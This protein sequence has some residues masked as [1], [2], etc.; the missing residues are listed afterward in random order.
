MTTI[1]KPT[2]YLETSTISYLAAR[3]PRDIHRK[4][5]QLITKK[6]WDTR[7][8]Y[9]VFISTTVLEEIEEGDPNAARERVRVIAG[10]PMLEMN[11]NVNA[12]GLA[13]L[14]MNHIPKNCRLD[15]FHLAFAAV[16]GMDFLVTWNQKH[17]IN[18]M[19]RRSI[20]D[21]IISYQYKFPYITTP[22]IM[23]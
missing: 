9:D 20:E 10:I 21:V 4:S 17:L 1:R 18:A 8:K 23:D 3:E 16:Y 14:Q 5:K 2:V 6:W 13:I 19:F 11:E 12:L 7:D 22:E 15:A